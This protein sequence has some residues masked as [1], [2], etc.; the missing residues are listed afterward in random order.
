VL[1]GLEIIS[2]HFSS[3]KNTKIS[4]G[5]MTKIFSF[6]VIFGIT[7]IDF[8]MIEGNSNIEQNQLRNVLYQRKVLQEEQADMTK[9][10]PLVQ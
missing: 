7:I 2:G 3:Q 8:I 1:G 6:L 10:L 4:L 5:T 9:I